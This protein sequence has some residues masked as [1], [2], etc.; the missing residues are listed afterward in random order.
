MAMTRPRRPTGTIKATAPLGPTSGTTR[1]KYGTTKYQAKTARVQREREQ[2]RE[3]PKAKG[4]YQQIAKEKLTTTI[5]ELERRREQTLPARRELARRFTVR[6][7]RK[8]RLGTARAVRQVQ[9]KPTPLSSSNV[10]GLGYDKATQTMVVEFHD[11][12]R[13]RYWNITP[14]LYEWVLWGKNVPRTTGGNV[15]GEW[16]MG[17]GPSVGAALYWDVIRFPAKYPYQKLA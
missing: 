16:K 2:F 8:Q 4:R 15:Y 17:V 10:A 14:E 9:S 12:S 6:E 1:N 11:R 5:R 3:L 7:E 13:Y